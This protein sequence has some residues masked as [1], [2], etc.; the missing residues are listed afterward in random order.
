MK[1]INMSEATLY[2][3]TIP[4]VVIKKFFLI[5]ERDDPLAYAIYALGGVAFSSLKRLDLKNNRSCVR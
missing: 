4:I 2:I 3:A 1:N 5:R